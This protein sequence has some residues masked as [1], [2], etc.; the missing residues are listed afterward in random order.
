M[1]VEEQEIEQ[2][3][4]EDKKDVMETEADLS[5]LSLADLPQ[6]AVF[7]PK[8][9]LEWDRLQAQNKRDDEELTRRLAEAQK[10]KS[11]AGGKDE[12]PATCAVP[13]CGHHFRGGRGWMICPCMKYVI[14]SSCKTSKE[15]G[16]E[17]KQ[18]MRQHKNKCK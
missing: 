5:S 13:S 1:Q 12:S 15:R 10:R 16:K 17:A 7:D 6:S 14:Y 4:I 2:K 18:M 8:E 3:L 11:A 9:L